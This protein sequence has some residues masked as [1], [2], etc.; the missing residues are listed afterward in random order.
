LDKELPVDIYLRKKRWKWTLFGAAV[1][2]VSVSLYYTSILVEEIRK[3]ERKN[4]QIWADA[5]HRKADLVN[6]TNT[7]FEQI[8]DEE[9]RRVIIVAE[10]QKRIITATSNEDLNFFLNIISN[11]TTIPVIL[12]D[13][14]GNITTYRNVKLDTVKRLEGELK[15]QFS[16]YP[17]IVVTYLGTQAYL[18]YRDS[19]IFTELKRVIDDL[20]QSFF[21][22]V[23]LNSASVPVIITDSTQKNVVAFGNIPEG[24][25]MT[26]PAFVTVRL[27]S[28]TAEN[29]PIRVNIAD[30][31]IRYI[32]YED[33]FLLTQLKYYPFVQFAV[34]GLFLFI[35][36]LLFSYAR[37]SEQNQVWVGMAKETAHQLG[38]PLSSMVAWVE[39]LKLK[40]VD[41]ETLNEIQKDVT[42]L[43]TIT[44]RFSKIGSAAKLEKTDI[45]A[46]V[47]N[48]I[49]YIK[50]RTSPRVTFSF[51]T[52]VEP[53]EVPLNLHLFEWVI[54]NLCKNAVD[55]M[56]GA[57][58]ISIEISEV[59]PE[60][61]LDISDTG[62]G[63][64]KSL[65]RTIFHPGYTSKARGWGLGL[66][67][68]RRIIENY[69]K[70]R[71]FVKSSTLN[72][73]TTF[74]IILK[75]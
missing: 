16:V 26:N 62:K 17:P 18:Y 63:I 41:E 36:Y 66:T 15:R 55:A 56:D 48:T 19:N 13:K 32:F 64:P 53:I 29:K 71:I 31:G 7:L 69:H 8:K 51:S 61:T 1:V 44:D 45:V 75:K 52:T 42:R 24:K 54:E 11:N 12:T 37:K 50:T 58:R 9:R 21:A 23:V 39:L 33:S 3:D 27:R 70:G 28:M 72:R 49:S 65:F 4:V 34:I 60:V 2:I 59:D 57:G 74:R 38:T 30:T 6:F 10:A 68:S 47:R 5:I 46:V 67:L 20:M 73:G 40:G 14:N 35:A 43:E 22:E 25:K